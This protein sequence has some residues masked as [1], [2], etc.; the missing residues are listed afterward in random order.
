MFYIR[1]TWVLDVLADISEMVQ[2]MSPELFILVHQQIMK[3][4][5]VKF[6]IL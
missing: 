4:Y 3:R 5:T 2:L 1:L 6:Y